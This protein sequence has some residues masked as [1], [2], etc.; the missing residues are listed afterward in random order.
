MMA[1]NNIELKNSIKDVLETAGF[2]SYDLVK[3]RR[4][5]MFLDDSDASGALDF[6]A[7][8]FKKTSDYGILIFPNGFGDWEPIK[9]AA[10]NY[11]RMLNQCSIPAEVLLYEHPWN[12]AAYVFVPFDSPK[13]SSVDCFQQ[14]QTLI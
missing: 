11:S 13:R 4:G 3:F 1:V 8:E 10:E 5:F 14:S 7:N 6:I 2:H 9:Q 12:F